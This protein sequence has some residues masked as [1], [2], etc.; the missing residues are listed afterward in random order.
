MSFSIYSENLSDQATLTA[1]TENL[2]FP[3]SNINDPRRS[4]VFRSTSNNDSIVFDFN[5]ASQVDSFFIVGDKRSGFGVSTITLQFNATDSWG[6][7][8]A[9]EVVTFS[10]QH[11]VGFK[12]FT[13]THNYRFCRMVLTSTLGYCEIS[14]V[15]LGKKLT[16]SR[17]INFGWSYRANEV[18]RETRNRYLQLFSDVIL[19]QRRISC[20]I[21]NMNKEDLDEF[22][23]MYDDKGETKPFFIVLGCDGQNTN[24]HRRYSGM[25]YLESVPP[26]PNP[27][28]NKYNVSMSLIEAT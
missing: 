3:L 18:S 2:L 5:E 21:S 23:K 6:A 25:Y 1:S 26:I 10:T 16:I 27:S 24:D 20:S 11:G 4:K 17:G 13:A 28:F 14:N 12:E 22:F 9:S 8:A 15:F 19:R 7:P